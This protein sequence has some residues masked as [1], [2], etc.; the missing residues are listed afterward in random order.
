MPFTRDGYT[1]LDTSKFGLEDTND[2]H[3]C[4][5]EQTNQDNI[6]DDDH[7]GYSLDFN[8]PKDS[9]VG[10]VLRSCSLMTSK[11]T[12]SLHFVLKTAFGKWPIALVILI[13]Y[14]ALTV[15]LVVTSLTGRYH[16]FRTD[17]SLDSFMVP[18]TKVSKDY[19]SFNTAKKQD[20]SGSRHGQFLESDTCIGNKI[21]QSSK[22]APS[23][24]KR[25]VPVFNRYQSRISGTLDLI[26]V[27]KGGDNIFTKERLDEIH[28]IEK[29][30][31]NHENYQKHCYILSQNKQDTA[32]KKSNNC[33]SPNSLT[34]F[35]YSTN[36]TVKTFDGQSSSL[37]REIDNTLEYLRSYK[38]VYSYVSEDFRKK[39]IS[40]IMRAQILFGKPLR[41]VDYSQDDEVFKQYLITYISTLE[42]LNNNK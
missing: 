33:T 7:L 17:I 14:I 41:G 1:R 27:A 31:M 36:F 23:R 8:Q 40:N 5:S 38:F 9:F 12:R 13:C 3:V 24:L 39:N 32:S 2:L 6:E 21:G 22:E 29:T 19:A 28:K 42:K 20:K 10:P 34:H 11:F 15:G 16:E 18:D 35:F 26:Y 25:S 37:P 4:G 30:L